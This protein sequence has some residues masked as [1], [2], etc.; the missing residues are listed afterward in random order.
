MRYDRSPDGGQR[1]WLCYKKA[2]QWLEGR[3][4][5]S[6]QTIIVAGSQRSGTNMVMDILERHLSTDVYHERD[7][8]AYQ[9]YLMR[10]MSVILGLRS[11]SRA[12]FFVIK[13]LCE[14]HLF[15]EILDTLAPAKSIWVLRWYG[16]AVHSMT[17]SF[18]GFNDQLRRLVADRL[19]VGWRGLG[20]SDETH[21][22]L[23]DLY[24]RCENDATAAALQWY[25]R[26]VLFFERGLSDDPR[27]RLLFY[28]T[29]VKSPRSEIEAVCEFVS[30]SPTPHM[31]SHVSSGS[32]RYRAD[33]QIH[34]DVRDLCERLWCRFGADRPS[35][36]GVS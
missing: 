31:W 17:R 5:P 23:R 25:C 30:I 26:N 10:E 7:R 3:Q 22:I 20:M 27:V 33:P 8:R 35:R 24:P 6:P 11:R 14:L 1:I 32:A 34:P 21:E 4:G 15:P 29:L 28:E 19:S 36:T 18:S 2:R 12:P 16:D 9:A 13:A